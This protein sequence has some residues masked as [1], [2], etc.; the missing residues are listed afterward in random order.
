MPRKKGLGRGLGALIDD[1]DGGDFMAP[2]TAPSEI[3]PDIIS[4]NPYQPRRTIDAEDLKGL[5]ESIKS[6]GVLEPLLVKPDGPDSYVLIAGERRLQASKAAGLDRVPVVVREATPN[7]MLEISLIENLHREDLNP[8][9]EAEAYQRLADEFGH[10]QAKIAGITGRDRS[11][12]ANIMRLLQLPEAVRLDLVHNRLTIGHARAMLSL[13]D[14]DLMLEVRR[15]VLEGQ[16]S[17]RETERLIKK[18]LKPPVEKPAKES[19]DLYLQALA[20]QITR[21]LGSKAKLIRQ[22]GKGRIEIRFSSDQELERLLK[23]FNV[24]PVS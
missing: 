17:V 12:V 23:F 9:E 20:D 21:S 5:I 16:L 10:T 1:M 13:E 22:G 2:K 3:S 24:G 18:L 6:I 8:I 14:Q 19:D 7:E 4:S 15:Q 11:T